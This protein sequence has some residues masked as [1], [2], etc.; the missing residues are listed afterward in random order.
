MHSPGNNDNSQLMRKMPDS[1]PLFFHKRGPRPIQLS[2]I[3]HILN[4]ESVFLT[5]PTASGKTEAAIAPLYQRHISFRREHLSV[6]YVAPTKALV[7]DIYYRL[8]DYLGVGKES[9]CVCRYTGD[10]HDFKEPAGSF[11]LVTT[12]EALD[13]LQL[14]KSQ[15]LEHIRVIVIDEVHFLHGKARGE[16]LRYV[17]DRIRSKSVEPK[18]KRDVFQIVAMSATLNDM[19]GVGRLWAGDTVRLVSA[20]DPRE[21]EMDFLQVP[22]GN[23]GD[24]AEEIAVKIKEFVEARKLEKVLIFANT[25]NDAHHLSVALDLVFK[26]TRWPVHLHFGILEAKVRDEIEADLKSNRYGICVSTS[27][28]ELG[29][30]IGDI[31]TILLLS[32]PLTVS[33]FLQRIG[34]GNRR[35]DTCKVMALSRND[36]ERLLYQALYELACIGSLEPVHEYTRPSV[37]FQQIL[38]HAW[39]GL[40]TDKPLTVKNLVIRS[41]GH[42]FGEHLKDMLAEGHLRLNQGALIPSDQLI[43]QGARRTIHSVIAGDSAKPVFDSVTGDA[44]AAIGA[45]AGEGVYFLGGQLR[46]IVSADRGSYVLE[47]VSGIGEKRIGKIPAARGGRGMSRTLAWKIAELTGNDPST[48]F[49]SK[50]RLVTWGG[51][52][53]NLLLTYIFSKHGLGTPTGFDGFGID[54]LAELD[55]ISP[56]GIAAIVDNYGF[57]LKLKQAEKFRESSRYYSYLG[58]AMKT[59]ESLGAVPM[60]EFT[61][62]LEECVAGP[63]QV[64]VIESEA[65]PP[66]EVAIQVESKQQPAKPA[67]SDRKTPLTRLQLRLSW[68]G[69]SQLAVK[70]YAGALSSLFFGA[71]GKVTVSAD[72]N[73]DQGD[74][75]LKE[76]IDLFRTSQQFRVNFFWSP[77][78]ST[79]FAAVETAGSEIFVTLPAEWHTGALCTTHRDLYWFQSDIDYLSPLPV[80]SLPRSDAHLHPTA[81]HG[82]VGLAKTVG[83]LAAA[84]LQNEGETLARWFTARPEGE[85]Y[86]VVSVVGDHLWVA[87][88]ESYH[89]E[90]SLWSQLAAE[91]DTEYP[92]LREC[93]SP[94]FTGS[95]PD[96]SVKRDFDYDPSRDLK[97]ALSEYAPGASLTIDKWRFSSAALFSPYISD[98]NIILEKQQSYTSCA[99]CGFVSLQES[100]S[101]APNCPCCGNSELFRQSFIT[102]QGFA[103]D[104]NEKREV[105]KGQAQDFA[106]RASRAQLEVQEPPEKWD[107]ELYEE[108]LAVIAGPRNLV[109]VNKGVGDRGFIVCPNCG[110]S[111]P[112]FGAGYPNSVMFKGGL[113]RQHYHPLEQGVMCDGRAAG[114][115]FFGHSFLTDVI[116]LRVK[117]AGPVVCSISNTAE[118]SGRAGQVALTSFVE[119][120]CLAASNTLQI[121]EGELSGNWCPVPWHAASQ[122]LRCRTWRTESFDYI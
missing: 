34:R 61:K 118:R 91:S 26:G 55:G 67:V 19:D 74:I 42:D 41:G 44:V 101:A 112:V 33:S 104:I 24:R 106:G 54:G 7:N 52:D 87:A 53:N 107:F 29:V 51:W 20:A 110:R 14:T 13:S 76:C 81:L 46:S 84:E 23:L 39:Q 77:D 60:P 85:G 113:P 90:A 96:L 102:P 62:W 70:S 89:G 6:L 69:D 97:I 21:I 117:V 58:T 88:D 75:D 111:E 71:S 103:P 5:A 32:P 116:L 35:S 40:R 73:S 11:I 9:S 10:H 38:S 56:E 31:Q 57:D 105:D 59:H 3:P 16:Q 18:D 94:L 17:I 65:E 27:T 82:L 93:L 114:P 98:V 68:E 30:D 37:V 8:S 66:A 28:L 50:G 119:A 80:L 100:A 92:N 120:L 79:F 109:T 115:F 122:C 121:E 36:N 22:D 15:K 43:D 12:P 63:L 25:R 48:W 99:A 95:T 78:D 86:P 72:D 49:W 64:E 83:E 4:G 1:W 45:G 2:A 47:R 108:K